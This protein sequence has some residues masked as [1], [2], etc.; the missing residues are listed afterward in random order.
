VRQP[1]RLL[2]PPSPVRRTR[3]PTATRNPSR[4]RPQAPAPVST[5]QRTGHAM[6]GLH[7]RYFMI[8]VTFPRSIYAKGDR[9]Q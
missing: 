6:A 9:D 3:L 7:V 8:T 4:F 2:R 1:R 5:N